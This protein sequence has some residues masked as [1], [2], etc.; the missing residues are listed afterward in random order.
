VFVRPNVYEPGRAN[1]IVYN[2]S[3]QGSVSVNVANV[4]QVGDRYEVRNVQ[5]LFGS[6]LA[7][8]TFGGGT[9]TLP[10]TPVSPPVPVGFVSSPS[11]TT[12][13]D[14]NVFLLTKVTN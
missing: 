10:M 3:R 11:P 4:L 1:I 9:I 13:P 5:D 8:G 7:S 6:P 14:F 2:W 12:G